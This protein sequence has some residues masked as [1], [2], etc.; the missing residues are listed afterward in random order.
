MQ[1]CIQIQWVT[2][3]LSIKHKLLKIIEDQCL[4]MRGGMPLPHLGGVPTDIT[5][6]T[7]IG[8]TLLGT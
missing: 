3:V 6:V 7:F 4:N 1:I 5:G 2:I 8:K